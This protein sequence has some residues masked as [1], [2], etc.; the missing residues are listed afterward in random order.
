MVLRDF[1][2]GDLEITEKDLTNPDIV[3]QLGYVP[4]RIDL[5]TGVSGLNFLEAFQKKVKG[6]YLGVTAYFISIP[7]LL[8]NK[9][10]SGREKDLQD[11][12]WVLKYSTYN[13]DGAG[14]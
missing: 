10:A 6:K 1:G 11:I 9:R 2:F 12:K 5:M 7:D 8:K 4:L 3:V 14:T 13:N